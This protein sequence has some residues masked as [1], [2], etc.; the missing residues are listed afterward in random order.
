M[1]KQVA[2]LQSNAVAQKLSVSVIISMTSGSLSKDLTL[3]NSGSVQSC[4]SACTLMGNFEF[5][6]RPL[7]ATFTKHVQRD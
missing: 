5:R 1:Q 3:M 4:S 7:Q 2:Y 6:I